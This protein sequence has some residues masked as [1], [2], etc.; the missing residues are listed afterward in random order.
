MKILFVST[1]PWGTGSFTVIEG[2]K[3]ELIKMG[4]TVTIFFP[5][6][7]MNSA[8]K[9]EYYGRDEDYHI[10]HFPIEKHGI[11]IHSFPLMIPDPHPRSPNPITYK[12]LS[13]KQRS[14]Y[15][16]ECQK[17]LYLLIKQFQPDVIECQHIWYT[18]WILHKMKTNY[19]ITAHHS[20]QMGFRYDEQVRPYAI[21]GAHHAKKIFAISE[22]VKK[23][24]IE[25]YGVDE[26]KIIVTPNG[27]DKD[28]F[29]QKEVNRDS[30]LKRLNLDIPQNAK[31]ISFAGKLSLTKGIDLILQ[32][33][34]LLDPKLNIHLIIMGAGSINPILE[35]M[36]PRTY[37]MKQIHLVGHQPPELVA[38][39]HNISQLSI[40]PSRNEGFGVAC[41]EA[42]G[43]GLPVVATRCGGPE[44]YAVGKIIEKNSPQQLADAMEAI[45][46]LPESE[47]KKLCGKAFDNAEQFSWK[48]IAETHIEV[49]KTCF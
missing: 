33:N 27:Y 26:S 22:P 38:K 47:Y 30:V 40:I 17:E 5:D 44:S 24:I 3:K 32:A 4:H 41:L 48:K 42:M 18:S 14:L 10:W 36:D 35:Q 46:K 2:L 49:Y 11:S 34:K 8:D 28:V 39:I 13:S 9:K 25:L 23:D 7:D 12:E 29:N 6:S 21:E 45:I 16:E 37:S 31:I 20:D 43:C 19:V 1:G 15:F